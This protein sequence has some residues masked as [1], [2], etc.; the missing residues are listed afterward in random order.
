ML[1]ATQ[2]TRLRR[3]RRG[4]A[5]RAAAREL[6]RRLSVILAQ[7][8]LLGEVSD[9]FQW[10]TR[11]N[12]S[13]I[14]GSPSTACL[15]AWYVPRLALPTSPPIRAVDDRATSLLAHLALLELHATPHTAEIDGHHAIKVF[16][17]SISGLRNH[18]L[19]TGIAESGIKPP[20]RG[21]RLLDH[22][23]YLSVIRYVATD[24]E[25]FVPLGGEFLGRRADG[26]LIAVRQHY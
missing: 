5:T 4:L 3:H 17:G 1:R 25:C 7:L 24:S 9:V 22:R 14:N 26:L 15:D 8:S 13:Q 19:N 6:Y 21:D 11:K 23:F 10:S 20:E 12:A 18:V 2:L 16:S